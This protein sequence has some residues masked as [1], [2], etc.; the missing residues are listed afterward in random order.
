MLGKSNDDTD[1]DDQALALRKQDHSIGT[2][3]SL[4]VLPNAGL[5]VSGSRDCSIRLWDLYGYAGKGV[6]C[7][8]KLNAHTDS[9]QALCLWDGN[10]G[11]PDL[12]A[13]GS[14]DKTICVWDVSGRDQWSKQTTLR[15][16]TVRN[17]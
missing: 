13:S 6:C 12:V 4:L 7:V 8:G 5:A 11:L 1:S 10:P 9:V 17:K 16:H 14:A 3:L 2:T 15:G